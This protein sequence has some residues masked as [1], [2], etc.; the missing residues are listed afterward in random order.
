M[1][2]SDAERRAASLSDGEGVWSWHPGLVLSAQGDDSRVTVTKR[3][4]T[5][6]R[7]R[8]ISRKT[9][10]RECRCLTLPVVTMLMC[11]FDYRT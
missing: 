7:A 3:S 5:P 2:E 11:F 10:R 6:A 8:S 1:D 4:W 9:L